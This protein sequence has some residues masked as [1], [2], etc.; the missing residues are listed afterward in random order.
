MNKYFFF[1]L[2]LFPLLL[3]FFFYT[4]AQTQISRL[5]ERE[6]EREREVDR[7]TE[8]GTERK[9]IPKKKLYARTNSL[10]Q[11]CKAN[12]HRT[13]FHTALRSSPESLSSVL[14]LVFT[15]WWSQRHFWWNVLDKSLVTGV[16]ELFP[17]L[18]RPSQDISNLIYIPLCSLQF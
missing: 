15:N 11:V 6:R 14:F 10:E 16:L 2:P 9:E 4:T 5:R 1:F 12:S 3:F 7:E 17:W 8:R 18:C 13:A